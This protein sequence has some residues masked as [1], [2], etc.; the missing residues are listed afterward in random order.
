[1]NDIFKSLKNNRKWHQENT[2]KRKEPFYTVLWRNEVNVAITEWPAGGGVPANANGGEALELRE[3]LRQLSVGDV[4]VEVADVKRRRRCG[5]RRRNRHWSINRKQTSKHLMLIVLEKESSFVGE[6]KKTLC[7]LIWREKWEKVENWL[8][9][10]RERERD[11][12]RRKCEIWTKGGE[13]EGVVCVRLYEGV[14]MH[15]RSVLCTGLTRTR[16]RG[17]WMPRGG[18]WAQSLPFLD[19]TFGS[20]CDLLFNGKSRLVNQLSIADRDFGL[21]WWCHGLGS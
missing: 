1:M 13:R 8:S 15:G 20:F 18:S 4:G 3:C 9:E 7:Q 10:G 2:K 21:W 11:R 16:R 12:E 17:A 19:L 14:G 5:H 6:K